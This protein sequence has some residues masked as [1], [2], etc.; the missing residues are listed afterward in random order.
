MGFI[1]Q[2]TCRRCGTKFSSLRRRCPSCG[3]RRVQQSTRSPGTTPSAVRG[4]AASTK[5]MENRKWQLIFGAI[6]VVAIIIAVIVMISV[7]LPNANA[8][9]TPSVADRP[10]DTPPAATPTPTATPEPSPSP[11]PEATPTVTALN[12]TYG[13]GTLTEFVLR[14]STEKTIQ[15][16]ASVTPVTVAADSIEWTSDDASI[17]SVSNGLVTAV[18]VGTTTIHATLYGV[19]ADCTVYVIDA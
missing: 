12:I 1:P 5:V 18:G 17:V 15:L 16:G 9:T 14:L 6:L 8:P 19:T 7:S 3:T 10:E 2:I 11:T 4:T 13:G